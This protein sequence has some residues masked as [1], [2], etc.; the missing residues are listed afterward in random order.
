MSKEKM[1]MREFLTT[2]AGNEELYPEDMVN[3]AKGRIKVLDETNEKR[4][5]KP[6]KVS[7]STEASRRELIGKVLEVVE[8]DKPFLAKEVAVALNISPQKASAILKIMVEMAML[9]KVVPENRNKPLE[10]LRTF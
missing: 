3:F 9:E 2:I 4:K 8:I 7:E 6:K 5:G 1:T 10:Y